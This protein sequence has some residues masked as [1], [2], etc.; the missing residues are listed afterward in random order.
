MDLI[1]DWIDLI[2][3]W[4]DLITVKHP[5]NPD[6]KKKIKGGLF[7]FFEE[8]LSKHSSLLF[9]VH[10][11]KKCAHFFFN[12]PRSPKRGVFGCFC[13]EAEF[14]GG[15]VT[16]HDLAPRRTHSD[17]RAQFPE[18]SVRGSKKCLKTSKITKS[19]FFSY[20]D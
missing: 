12:R 14:W 13:K 17:A 9:W 1:I 15:S 6:R 18:N 11:K 10:Q 2:N 19:Q 20:F 16:S 7:Q 4:I 8:R 5:F 3:D